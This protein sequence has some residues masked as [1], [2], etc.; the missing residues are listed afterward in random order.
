MASTE[1]IILIRHRQC[2]I[3]GVGQALLHVRGREL[4]ALAAVS[5]ERQ[6]I[7]ALCDREVD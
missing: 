1:Q 4:S 6:M 3:A 5:P 7:N 2:H